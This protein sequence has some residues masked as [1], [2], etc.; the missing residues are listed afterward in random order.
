MQ[1]ELTETYKTNPL[2]FS[3]SCSSSSSSSDGW[4]RN[5]N[6]SFGFSLRASLQSAYSNSFVSLFVTVSTDFPCLPLQFHGDSFP[7]RFRHGIQRRCCAL[8]LQRLLQALP[9]RICRVSRPSRQVKLLFFDFE[10]SHCIT[11]LHY[12][13]YWSWIFFSKF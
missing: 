5:F 13:L 10:S 8:D 3:V 6:G 2:V 11:Y 1:R 7:P 9:I 12:F 4:F